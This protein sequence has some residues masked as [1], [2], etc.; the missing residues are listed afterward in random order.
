MPNREAKRRKWK[1]RLLNKKWATEGRTTAQHKKWLAK[2]KEKGV[3]MPVY[4]RI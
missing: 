2:Q 4:G 1:K 3:Q